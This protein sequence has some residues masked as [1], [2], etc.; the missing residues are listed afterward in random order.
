MEHI[1]HALNE[2][3]AHQ[4]WLLRCE[5]N[6]RDE[7]EKE[8]EAVKAENHRLNRIVQD[9]PSREASTHEP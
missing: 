4:N 3:I 6:A 1:L 8:L 7:V 2:H 9:H 5:R